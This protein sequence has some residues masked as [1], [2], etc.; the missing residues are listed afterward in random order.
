MSRTEVQNR[1]DYYVV[2]VND[3]ADAKG[4]S[5]VE[6]FD[7]VKKHQGLDFLVDHYDIEHTYPIEEAVA[8]LGLVCAC[9]GGALK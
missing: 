6:A 4:L 9:N 1:I 5:Y 2:C 8:D 3:F 7:Y